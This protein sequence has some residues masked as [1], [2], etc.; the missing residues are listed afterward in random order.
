MSKN[1]LLKDAIDTIETLLESLTNHDVCCDL[2]S[3]EITE[4]RQTIEKLL[5]EVQS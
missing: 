2:Y 4:A 3:N 1:E 5:S